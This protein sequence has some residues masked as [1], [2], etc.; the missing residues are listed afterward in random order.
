MVKGFDEG[1]MVY[2]GVV[3]SLGKAAIYR[4]QVEDKNSGPPVIFRTSNQ[5]ITNSC[6]VVVN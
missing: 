2:V 3:S 4:V 6:D 1:E 5:N